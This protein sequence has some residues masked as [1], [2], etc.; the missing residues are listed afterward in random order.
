[1][2]YWDFKPSGQ[3]KMLT[4][5]ISETQGQDESPKN[6]FQING[7]NISLGKVPGLTDSSI[8]TWFPRTVIKRV[9][10]FQSNMQSENK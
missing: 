2:N 4:F 5:Y 8:Q 9:C 7:M 1:M 10:D 3:N 6:M